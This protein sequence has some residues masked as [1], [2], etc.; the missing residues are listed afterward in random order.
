MKPEKVKWIQVTMQ[1]PDNETVVWCFDQAYGVIVGEYSKKL[2]RWFSE[3]GDWLWKV[4]H[5]QPIE[6]PAPPQE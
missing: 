1:L 2:R 5:W 6:K 4:T 3:A